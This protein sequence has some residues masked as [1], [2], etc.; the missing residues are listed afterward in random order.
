MSKKK[1]PDRSAFRARLNEWI[2]AHGGKAESQPM[3]NSI[4]GG[5][6]GGHWIVSTRLGVLMVHM[7]SDYGMLCINTRFMDWGFHQLPSDANPHSGKWNFIWD[8]ASED[9]LF[10]AFTSRLERLL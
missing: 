8:D 9:S 3:P 2:V 4:L 6:A 5:L 10:A 7:P 1:N